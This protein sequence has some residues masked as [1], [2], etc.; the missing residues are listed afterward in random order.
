VRSA[1]PAETEALAADAAARLVAGDVVLVS[2]ELGVGKTT[3]VRGAARGLGVREPVVS[4]TFTIGARY[5]GRG[6]TVAHLDL[7][8]LSELD[9][10][11]PA[12]L[13][14]Y[15]SPETIAFVE[16][17]ERAEEEALGHVVLRVALEHVGGDARLITLEWRQDRGAA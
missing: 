4:P 5:R 2:G 8:R 10:E 16:W 9:D 17:P 15:L 13:A 3:F 11:D 1:G 14:D 12:L 6:V 7:Y